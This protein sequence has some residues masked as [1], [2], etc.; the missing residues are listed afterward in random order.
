MK[1]TKLTKDI[2]FTTL[3]DP[4]RDVYLWDATLP[5][6][7]IKITPA[8]S[9]VALY[10]YRNDGRTRR[11]TIG[12][13][14]DALTIEQARKKAKEGAA[15]LLDGIDPHGEKIIR[16]NALS[17]GDLLDL[18]LKSAAFTDKAESTRQTDS[19]RIERHLRPLLGNQIADTVTPDQIAKAR[20][21][22]IDG[23]T[24]KVAKTANKRGKSIVRGG[25]GAARKSIVLL[26]AIYNWAIGESLLTHNPA[27]K[28]ELDQ[29]GRRDVIIDEAQYI[30]LFNA[31][32]TLEN[33]HQLAHAAAD[34]IRLIAFTGARRGEIV[35]LRW[36]HIDRAAGRIVISKAEHKT[37]RK[38]Q[39]PRIIGLSPESLEIIDRQ[40]QREPDD[41]VFEPG[42]GEG[43]IDLRRP[44]RLARTTANL[45]ADFVLHGLRHS[46]GSHLAMGGA[47][48]AEIQTALGHRQLATAQRY[49]H[50][51]ETARQAL[52]TKAAAP[53]SAAYAK[54][55]SH[56]ED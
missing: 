32:D 45:P 49:I 8:G 38:T 9:R 3:A 24:A 44:W 2:V 34:A 27:T 35:G 54:K 13:L 30:A 26:R 36:R 51:A 5:G 53:I 40:E 21:A 33:Q 14:S 1:T 56:V 11:L 16:R 39:A 7:G 4:V 48:M 20:N 50:F 41:L 29:D 42:R 10:Q 19:G 12:K 6:F 52:T 37:G 46:V 22:I 25:T 15:A 18:Y 28:V 31:L 43:G 47:N 55:G 17:I 23:K